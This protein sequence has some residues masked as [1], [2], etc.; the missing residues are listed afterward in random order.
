MVTYKIL[1]E[2]K[3]NSLLFSI[4][5]TGDAL[6]I[7]LN[8]YFPGAKLIRSAGDAS[9]GAPLGQDQIRMTSSIIYAS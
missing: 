5:K 4:L 1:I 8:A 2:H 9:F 6:K 3:N 7:S